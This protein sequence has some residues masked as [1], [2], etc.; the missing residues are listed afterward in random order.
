M[1][2]SLIHNSQ[3]VKQLKL[4]TSNKYKYPYNTKYYSTIQRNEML[5]H[6]MDEHY[7]LTER[8]QTKSDIVYD[9][10]YMNYPE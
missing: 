10:I 5:M 4:S 6:N 7:R 8:S 1:F 9:S 3:N 2:I